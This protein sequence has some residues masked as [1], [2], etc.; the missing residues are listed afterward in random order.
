MLIG[1]SYADRTYYQSLTHVAQI[2]LSV[3]ALNSRLRYPFN[4][5][6][7]MIADHEIFG[8]KLSCPIAFCD[9][10]T[11]FR[12]PYPL[13][14]LVVQTGAFSQLNIKLQETPNGFFL[15]IYDCM[16]DPWSESRVVM[17]FNRFLSLQGFAIHFGQQTNHM[18]A[19]GVLMNTIALELPTVLGYLWSLVNRERDRRTV[20]NSRECPTM[21]KEEYVPDGY[22]KKLNH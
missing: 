7:L 19:R 20:E 18:Q 22:P 8:T 2:C 21:H 1:I 4:T 17:E 5:P 12:L 11:E 15:T 10:F 13:T 16:G 9:G 3:N 14:E 6:Q